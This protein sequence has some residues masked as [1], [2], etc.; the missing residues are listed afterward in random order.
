MKLKGLLKALRCHTGK[1]CHQQHAIP[2]FPM[3][4]KPQQ[5]T[6]PFPPL[7]YIKLRNT[8]QRQRETE[9]VL[10]AFLQHIQFLNTTSN[11]RSS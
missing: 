2:R 6:L 10:Y 11:Y 8:R 9:D 1:Q 3:A 5:V 4:D 7:S